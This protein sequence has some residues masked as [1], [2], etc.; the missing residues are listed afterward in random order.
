MDDAPNQS[1]LCLFASNACF[2]S[3]FVRRMIMRTVSMRSVPIPDTSDRI[4]LVSKSTCKI[5]FPMQNPVRNPRNVSDMN[6]RPKAKAKLYS[7]RAR[8]I[9]Y[10][11][12]LLKPS[13]LPTEA[14]YFFH[15]ARSLISLILTEL[16]A[17]RLAI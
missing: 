15:S 1:A 11:F 17:S 14:L 6:P 13:C 5:Y 12:L 4:K 8:L 9:S 10:A 3:H 16:T 2:F 7:S